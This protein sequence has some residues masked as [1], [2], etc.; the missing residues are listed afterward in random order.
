VRL[1]SCL[2]SGAT[3]DERFAIRSRVGFEQW[4]SKAPTKFDHPVAH[5]EVKRFA[6]GR[7][8]G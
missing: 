4:I 7:L 5:D 1:C 3:L 6:R 8:A 2:R